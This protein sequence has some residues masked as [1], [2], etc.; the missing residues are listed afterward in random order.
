MPVEQEPIEQ[1]KKGFQVVDRWS[2]TLVTVKKTRQD[3]GFVVL[4]IG[5]AF[6]LEIRHEKGTLVSVWRRRR[7]KERKDDGE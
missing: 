4:E 7:R 1:V 2:G 3:G 5:E 6:C